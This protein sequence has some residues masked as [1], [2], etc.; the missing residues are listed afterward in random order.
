[1]KNYSGTEKQKNLDR[2]LNWVNKQFPGSKNEILARA[3]VTLTFPTF[4]N[5]LSS[6]G[7][8]ESSAYFVGPPSALAPTP[9]PTEESWTDIF[10][11][12]ADAAKTIV[13]AYANY[14]MQKDNY[15]I[16]LERA[17]AGLPPLDLSQTAPQIRVQ[18]AVDYEAL[19]REMEPDTEN[20]LWI[21]AAIIG[22]LLLI[23]N[24]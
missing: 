14:E 18:H 10:G 23:G 17:K 6:L 21:G 8:D 22:G 24:R 3:G 16:Q 5:Y 4:P 13:P 9:Q 20:L 15:N 12:I 2:F 7:Q 1:M 11:K 19:K